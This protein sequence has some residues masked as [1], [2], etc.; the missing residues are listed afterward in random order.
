GPGTP[1]GPPI[2]PWVSAAL[3]LGT[4]A[5]LLPWIAD[6]GLRIA[7]WLSRQRSAV[8][9]QRAAVVPHPSPP[10]QHA[11]RPTFH[12]SRFTFHVTL[13]GLALLAAGSLAVLIDPAPYT[14]LHGFVLAAPIVAC[15]ALA[16]R[17]GRREAGARRLLAALTA[18]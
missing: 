14:S 3:L 13:A 10:A 11:T 5:V 16:A 9:G 2:A 15:A 1:A 4:L 6:C 7:D 12:V 18:L 17:P 8:S